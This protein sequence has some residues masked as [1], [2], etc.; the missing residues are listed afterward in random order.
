MCHIIKCKHWMQYMH[1]TKATNRTSSTWTQLKQK[2]KRTNTCSPPL[3]YLSNRQR[4]E[5]VKITTTYSFAV[6][7]ELLEVYFLIV[8]S[9][10]VSSIRHTH[11]TKGSRG[12]MRSFTDLKSNTPT[13]GAWGLV[14]ETLWRIKAFATFLWI[15]SEV[16]PSA[17]FVG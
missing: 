7:N 8:I 4:W 16:Y 17:K 12:T 6:V 5:E 11:F 15:I 10:S 3:R 2:W 1:K 14:W 9:S 13:K